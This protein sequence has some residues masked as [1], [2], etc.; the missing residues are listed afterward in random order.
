MASQSPFD[1]YSVEPYDATDPANEPHPDHVVYQ[2]VFKHLKTQ[3]ERVIGLLRDTLVASKYQNPTTLA[4]LEVIKKVAKSDTTEQTMFAVCGNMG[5]G[6]STLINSLLSCGTVARSGASGDS[7]TWVVQRFMKPFADQNAAFAAKVYLFSPEEIRKIITSLLTKYFRAT[8]RSKLDNDEEPEPESDEMKSD[9]FTDRQSVLETMQALFGDKAEFVDDEAAERYL[10]MAKSETDDVIVNELTVWADSLAAKFLGGHECIIVEGST[11]DEL[12]YKLQPFTY[13]L[14]GD[15]GRGQISPWPLVNVIDFGLDSFLLQ[16]GIV[17]VDTPGL[18]DSDS[19]RAAN[20]ARYHRKCTHKITVADVARAKNDKTLRESLAQGYRLRRSAG[21]LLVLTKGDIIDGG[22]EVIGSRQEKEDEMHLNNDIKA[23]R[24]TKTALLLQRKLASADKKFD[25]DD[26]LQA[27]ATHIRLKSLEYDRTRARMRNNAVAKAVSEVYHKMTNDPQRL[28]V[29]VV[30]NEAY[31]AHEAGHTVDEKPFLSVEETDIPRLRAKI[32]SLPADGKLN[33]ALHLANVNLP[34]LINYFELYCSKTHMDRKSDIEKILLQ[35]AKDIKSVLKSVAEKL[36]SAVEK[37][38]L[39]PMAQMETQWVKEA[40]RLCRTWA[41]RFPRDSLGIMKRDGC[42]KGRKDQPDISWNQ[43]LMEME[44]TKEVLEE[45]YEAF[46]KELPLIYG[47]VWTRCFRILDT[48][49]TNISG[50]P[51]FNV[52]ALRPFLETFPTERSNIREQTQS[53]YRDLRH[54]AMAIQ[55]DCVMPTPSAYLFE[56]MKPVYAEVIQVKG[57]RG[58]PQRSMLLLERRVT[59]M[60]GVWMEVHD[61]IQTAANK[62]I[63]ENMKNVEKGM[64]EI[65][66][67]LHK[68]FNLLC[69]GR[70]ITDPVEKAQEEKLRGKLQTQVNEARKL[71]GGEIQ[72][73]VNACKTYTKPDKDSL[74][75]SDDE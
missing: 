12:L 38:I 29:F 64:L 68:K 74:F 61:R 16:E 53:G 25:F 11:T 1:D 31:Q 75:V 4:L 58:A 6:K 63:D 41:Q 48:T 47:E 69:E 26:K 73:L 28:A 65:F 27:N 32:Y 46:L 2:P 36:K 34:N 5:L 67:T 39:T 45:E 50:N 70:V 60:S 54:E 18:S 42:R 37:H 22:T 35:A 19:T 55:Q 20:A 8:D 44:C 9:S 52:M 71:M 40:R 57:G 59:S 21:T 24:E 51:Q 7:C 10:N 17:L 62:A 15:E 66:G 56:A 30:G 23:L 43:E 72:D 14:G 49:R 33:D 13:Q 3:E